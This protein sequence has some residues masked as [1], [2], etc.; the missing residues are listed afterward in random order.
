MPRELV[1]YAIDRIGDEVEDLV[2][3]DM[4]DYVD[5]LSFHD[6]IANDLGALSG[7]VFGGD[8]D[9]DNCPRSATCIWGASRTLLNYPNGQTFNDTIVFTGSATDRT[10]LHEGQHAIDGE[11]WGYLV[12]GVAYLA[13]SVYQGLTTDNSEG[14]RQNA[15][16]ENVFEQRARDA[17]QGQAQRP[18]SWKE[19][20]E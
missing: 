16:S 10:V 6:E 20:F 12:F 5:L 15:Y 1:E 17:Q 7:I 14:F 19:L 11:Q 8:V 3:F 18:W 13:E 9:G 4:G 2:D